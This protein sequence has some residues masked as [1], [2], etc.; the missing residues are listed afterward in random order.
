MFHYQKVTF[1]HSIVPKLC[2]S[3]KRG[4]RVKLVQMSDA[5]AAF[6][7]TRITGGS[8]HAANASFDAGRLRHG[9][10]YKLQQ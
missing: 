8:Q 3:R 10:S 4:R 5:A 1:Y 9:P 2:P 6:L 7:Y